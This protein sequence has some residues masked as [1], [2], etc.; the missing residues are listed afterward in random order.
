MTREA[1]RIDISTMPDLARLV[2]EVKR[3]RQP[4]ALQEDGETVA[5]LVPA[6]RPR[7]GTRPR[8]QLVDTSMLPPVPYRSVAELV[9]HQP[10]APARSF[11]DEELE[12]AI[13]EARAEAWRA[14]HQ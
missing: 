13:D 1:A 2:Q 11:T 3:T 8:R 4:Q 5:L 9:R 6:G 7:R 10:V 12:E 14:K